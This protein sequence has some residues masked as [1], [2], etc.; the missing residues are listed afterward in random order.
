MATVT[1]SVRTARGHEIGQIEARYDSGFPGMFNVSGEPSSGVLS[2]FDLF[3]AVP[4]RVSAMFAMCDTVVETNR[5]IV[6]TG[7]HIAPFF[8]R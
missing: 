8:A 7:L 2:G 4:R 3:G 1:Y 5:A 6:G